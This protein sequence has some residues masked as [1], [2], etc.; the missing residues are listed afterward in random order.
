MQKNTASKKILFAWC[1]SGFVLLFAGESAGVG[2][3]IHSRTAVEMELVG[4]DGLDEIPL[5]RE[6]VAAGGIQKI[7]TSYNGLAVLVFAGGQ[8]Y[9]VIIGNTS[10]TLNIEDQSRPPSFIGSD[11]NEYLYARLA[12]KDPAETGDSFAQLM[13][14]AKQLLDSN[15]SIHTTAELAVGKKEFHAFVRDNYAPLRRSDMVRRLVAQYFMMHEYVD[16]HVE[17]EPATSI[18]DSYQKAVLDGVA[19]WLETL[20]PH[21]P[22]YEILN[23]CVSLYY[24]R[25]M[26]SLAA[27]IAERFASAAYCPGIEQREWRFPKDLPVTGAGAK[28]KKA[29]STI[30]GGKMFAF[31]SDDC[32]VSMVGTVMQA[33]RLADLKSDVQVVIAPLEKLSEKHLAMNKMVSGGTM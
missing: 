26:V 22:E 30:K 9:P 16:Y 23:Y 20:K 28:D 33:R 7:D 11:A 15:S 10:F 5:V 32:P 1:L 24:T 25:S 3:T 8:R 17:G 13:V 14:Q 6:S 31:V 18:R 12:G 19:G 29:L 27:L 2:L 4:Y 21:I